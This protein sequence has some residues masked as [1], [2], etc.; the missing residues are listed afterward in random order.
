MSTDKFP[1][2]VSAAVV[3]A[4]HAVFHGDGHRK[5]P[6]AVVGFQFRHDRLS[7]WFD[8]ITSSVC[9]YITTIIWNMATSEERRSL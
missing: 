3:T 2:N 8:N 9:K 4:A 1:L 7:E 5:A 6:A